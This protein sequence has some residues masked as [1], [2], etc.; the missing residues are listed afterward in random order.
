[1]KLSKED[2]I[3]FIGD[4]IT[5]AQRILARP[6]DLGQGYVA[7]IAAQLSVPCTIINRGING[8][9]IDDL[10]SRWDYDCLDLNP[11]VVSIMIGINDTWDAYCENRIGNAFE[12]QRYETI[13]RVLLHR[14]KEHRVQ[15]IVL[16][17][18]FV[19]T[20]PEDRWL[21]RPDVNAK[22]EIVRKLALEYQTAFVSLD[23]YLNEQGINRSFVDYTG[24]D[25]VHPTAAGHAV[26]ARRW[27]D[28]VEGSDDA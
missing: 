11:D 5:A 12:T 4:S 24:S 9:R 22:I 8:D 27:L 21:W 2:T 16:M 25:G 18:P 17:E 1:M 20:Y 13:Y 28:V 26:I 3:V 15:R 7:A 19:L 23:G 10:R 14:L 6:T